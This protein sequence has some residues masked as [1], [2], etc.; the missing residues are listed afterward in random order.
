MKQKMCYLM[1][2]SPNSRL[3][4]TTIALQASG[5][6]HLSWEHV[7]KS[8]SD[9]I[10]SPSKSN[11]SI[12]LLMR[13]AQMFCRLT[14]R[15]YWKCM[16]NHNLQSEGELTSLSLPLFVFSSSESYDID[17]SDCYLR[18]FQTGLPVS[19]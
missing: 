14:P 19:N 9:F 18:E 12:Y 13:M 4:P 2:D 15:I 7:K 8:D 1:E 11:I 6:K 10:L 3:S 17:V 16:E 5:I